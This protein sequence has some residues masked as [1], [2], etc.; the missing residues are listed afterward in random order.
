MSPSAEITCETE[1]PGLE[2]AAYYYEHMTKPRREAYAAIYEGYRSFAPVIRTCGL[3]LEEL[4]DISFLLRLDH[5]ELFYLAA[6]RGRRVPGSERMELLP[7]YLFEKSKL[8]SHQQA[9]QTR[10]ARLTRQAENLDEA[11]RLRFVHDFICRNVRYD[12]LKKPYSH[13]IIGPL[14]Q[15]VGVCEGI[16]KTVRI[17]CRALRLPCIIAVSHAAP[18]RGVRYRHAWNVVRLGAA[19]YH[20]DAT[21]DLGL[22]RDGPVRYDYLCLDDRQIFR[23]HQP[24]VEPMP[25]CADGSRFYYRTAGLSLTT[26]EQVANR[27]G[28]AA[29]RKLDTFVFHWRGGALTGPVAA[30]LLRQAARQADRYGLFCAASVNWPQAVFCLRFSR[31]PPAVSTPVLEKADEDWEGPYP[32]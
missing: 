16:A 23:D 1:A 30:D 15:G 12:K 3:P 18:E 6:L 25:P 8:R 10:L 22:S 13:E 2:D 14:T 11:G 21:F 7:E 9:I 32:Y 29:R 28:Q 19:C 31:T 26:A 20:V 27:V 24:L 5:P 17:L 4:A